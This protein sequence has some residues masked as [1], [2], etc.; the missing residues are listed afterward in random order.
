MKEQTVLVVDDQMFIRRIISDYLENANYH[1]IEAKNGRE[2]LDFFFENSSS[3]HLVVLDIMMPEIDGLEVCEQIRDISAVPIIML[4]AS[5]DDSNELRGL[6]LGVD[7]YMK[8][9]FD[10]KELVQ[11]VNRLLGNPNGSEQ[12][13]MNI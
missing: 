3:V 11:T 4:T 13:I 8:K 9:P 2:A 6:R 12:N 1:V 7:E 10:G 5:D